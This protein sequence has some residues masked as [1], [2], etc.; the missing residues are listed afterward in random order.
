MELR[1]FTLGTRPFVNLDVLVRVTTVDRQTWLNWLL[2]SKS[3]SACFVRT[4]DGLFVE[5][6]CTEC[7]VRCKCTPSVAKLWIDWCKT[8][9]ARRR[10]TDSE[11]RRVASEQQ[12][13]CMMCGKELDDTYEVDHIEEHCIRALNDRKNLQAL[14]PHCHRVKTANDRFYGDPLFEDSPST[15]ILQGK[16]GNVFSA[17]FLQ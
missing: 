11:K 13:K 6:S 7:I 2:D 14:C 15:N 17:Y 3:V 10:L 5:V 12:W 16:D 8:T 9:N 1:R 4:R